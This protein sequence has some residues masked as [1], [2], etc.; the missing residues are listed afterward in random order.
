[1]KQPNDC[2]PDYCRKPVLVLGCGN[3]LFGDDGFGP[4]VIEHI[5]QGSGAPENACFL[6]AGS[7]VREILFNVSLSDRRPEEIIVV[8]AMAGGRRPGEVTERGLDSIPEIKRDDFSMHQIPTSNL[9]RE[10]RDFCGVAVRLVVLEPQEIPPEVKP[11]LSA[12]A[13]GA[14]ARAAEHIVALC[15]QRPTAGREP[16]RSVS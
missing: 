8:D 1:M 7:S 3:V 10:I 6:N 2:T 13:A 14:V 9:L 5:L 4:A 15:N 12:A 16:A 11:G